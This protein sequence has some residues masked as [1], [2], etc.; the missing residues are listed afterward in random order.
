MKITATK[1]LRQSSARLKTPALFAVAF[2]SAGF[3]PV[4]S[5]PAQDS[6]IGTVRPVSDLRPVAADAASR[7][8]QPSSQLEAWRKSAAQLAVQTSLSAQVIR[9][10]HEGYGSLT[11]LTAASVG[12]AGNGAP[13]R[14]ITAEIVASP[15]RQQSSPNA[16]SHAAESLLSTVM[17][18]PVSQPNVSAL[19]PVVGEAS[20]LADVHRAVV[21]PLSSAAPPEAER[22]G[23]VV[24]DPAPTLSPAPVE[25]AAPAPKLL[26]IDFVLSPTASPPVHVAPKRA[27]AGS[28]AGTSRM[29][30]KAAKSS[31]SRY[32]LTGRGV[33]FSMPVVIDGTMQGNVSMLVSQSQN[34]EVK[35]QDLL[36]I[37]AP[38]LSP[39]DLQRLG[40]SPAA[41][42]YVSLRQ[43]REAG[44]DLRYDAAL[45]RLRLSSS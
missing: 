6:F 26:A 9:Q 41:G 19:P 34:A 16:P 36:G 20:A 1:H 10:R 43:L 25:A 38:M 4:Q 24:S 31:S 21:Q 37:V 39:E 30:Q 29:A 12:I 40:N 8:G 44:I 27:S 45:D 13:H 18:P 33:E 23:L 3:A 35:L 42:E 7:F 2:S 32:R 14:S 5:I 28:D 17:T 11:D 22:A 15:A